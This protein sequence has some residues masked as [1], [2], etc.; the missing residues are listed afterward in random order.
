MKAWKHHIAQHFEDGDLSTD[1]GAMKGSTIFTDYNKLLEY[2]KKDGR[3]WYVAEIEVEEYEIDP[4][5][6]GYM[7]TI[8]VDRMS[9]T[10]FKKI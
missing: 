3:D 10:G 7:A 4:Y 5:L 6:C 2:L 1:G 8:L 9:N